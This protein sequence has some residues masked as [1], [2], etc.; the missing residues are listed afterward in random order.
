MSKVYQ[1]YFRSIHNNTLYTVRIRTENGT[2]SLDDVSLGPSPFVTSMETGGETMYTPIKSQSATIQIVAKDYYFD[3]Y[4]ATPKQ[5]KV[6]L[7]KGNLGKT[8]PDDS[9]P[10]ASIMFIGYVSPNVFDADYNHELESWDVEC[11]DGLSV[12][13]NYDYTPA[14]SSTKGFISFSKLIHNILSKCGCY[15]NWYISKALKVSEKSSTSTYKTFDNLFISEQN[16]FDED[17]EPM[18]MFDVLQEICKFLGV[19][20][21]AKGVDVYFID[22]DA[23]KAGDNGYYKYPI[24]S[25]TKAI[26]QSYTYSGSSIALDS[27]FQIDAN[28]YSSTGSRLSLDSVYSKVT[29]KDSLYKVGSIIPSMFDDEDLKNVHYV[30]EE[31]QNYDFDFTTTCFDKGEKSSKTDDDTYFKIK[32]K[33]YTNKKYIHNFYKDPSTGNVAKLYYSWQ[34]N[35]DV[36]DSSHDSSSGK[37]PIQSGISAE[38]YMGALFTKYAIGSGNTSAAA[39]GNIEFD[40]YENYLM[41]TQNYSISSGTDA[42][43]SIGLPLIQSIESFSKPFFMSGKTRLIA[44]GEL[45]IT[46]RGTFPNTSNNPANIGYWPHTGTFKGDYSGSS[47]FEMTKSGLVLKIYVDI[48]GA[49][50]TFN[51]P[52]Y[53]VGESQQWLKENKKT[54]EIFYTNFGIQD[55]IDYLDKIKEDGYRLNMNLSEDNVYPAKTKITIYGM[56]SLKLWFRAMNQMFGNVKSPVACLFIKDFDIVAQDPFEGPSNEINANDIEYSVVIDDDYVTELSPIEFKICTACGKSLNYSSVAYKQA[57]ST[58]AYTGVPDTSSTYH[59]LKNFRHNSL[60][61]KI[62]E[63]IEKSTDSEGHKRPEE[64]LCWRLVN[65]YSVPRRKLDI[66]LFDY[67]VEPYSLV[68]ETLLNRDFI[69]G[70]ISN[71]YRMETANV[72]LIEKG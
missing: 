3:F 57:N 1:G 14:D 52:F 25:T 11:V 65:Q 40:S 56:E 32:Y 17:D 49:S 18:K 19:S 63:S 21:V 54:H 31:N 41:L 55:N 69:V 28:S 5:N 35:P 62:L 68:K 47:A 20:A 6:I 4:A 38:N 70:S 23:V 12:L 9:I 46:D 44:K 2:G 37:I 29:V 26:S 16:F 22:Y 58:S 48:G 8:V 36:I 64:L 10:D 13:K 72:E 33:Y 51:V 60:N 53:G 27:S 7:C 67:L 43:G 42:D 15:K 71:D 50:N 24:N 30:S 61:S 39:S 45:I 34:E 66:N 59:F